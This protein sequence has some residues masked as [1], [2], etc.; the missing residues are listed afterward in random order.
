VGFTFSS[1][2]VTM[3]DAED[4]LSWRNDSSTLNFQRNN[5]Y[6]DQK[7][8]L[9][10]LVNRLEKS[11]TLPFTIYENEFLE[12][13][14]VIRIDSKE[15]ARVEISILINPRFR[16]RGYG[17]LMLIDFLSKLSSVYSFLELIAWIHFSN[18]PSLSLFK[19]VGFKVSGEKKDDFLE[20][21]YT[22]NQKQDE[23]IS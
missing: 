15:G 5:S 7:A 10:W 17:K 12:K 20:F 1:R 9:E 18:A 4:L 23:S 6:I 22:I 3:S 21:R 2:E 11:P 14:G 16:G 19:S 13:I 8:H